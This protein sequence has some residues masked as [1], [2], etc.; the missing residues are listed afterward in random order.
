M[1][2]GEVL[3][4]ETLL[5]SQEGLVHVMSQF[6]GMVGRLAF[7]SP[8]LVFQRAIQFYFNCVTLVFVNLSSS[9]SPNIEFC[10]F[11][12]PLQKNFAVVYIESD[13]FAW[14]VTVNAHESVRT[15]L[16]V[17]AMI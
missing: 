3:I 4:V 6:S 7:L 5:S 9:G 8:C 10:F 17:T 11:A 15:Q 12:S 14:L 1:K 2:N 13:E 16:D